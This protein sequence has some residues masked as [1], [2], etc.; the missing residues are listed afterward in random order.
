MQE[1]VVIKT[2]VFNPKVK[3]YRVLSSVLF[4]VVTIFG[5]PLLLICRHCSVGPDF[6]CGECSAAA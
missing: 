6:G 5:I 3:N 4:F 1:E 2:A